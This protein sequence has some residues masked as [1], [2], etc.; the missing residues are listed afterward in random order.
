MAPV[1][2]RTRN[3]V[4][5]VYPKDHHPPHVHVIGPNAEARFEIENLR[6]TYFRGFSFRDLGRIKEFLRHHEQTL[7]EAWNDYQE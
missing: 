6:C 7:W 4:V 5:R 3:L 1:V 2:L